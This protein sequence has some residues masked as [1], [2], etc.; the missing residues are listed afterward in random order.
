M[1]AVLVICGKSNHLT[2]H[3]Y[4]PSFLWASCV[5]VKEHL[6][7]LEILTNLNLILGL[8]TDKIS[9]VE[10]IGDATR[11]PIVIDLI[12]QGFGK[13]EL[14]R[15]LNSL[16][17]IGR[18]A[19]LQ[20]AMLSPLF[21]VSSFVVEEY[22]ALPVSITYRFGQ[23]EKTATRELFKKGSTFP[24]SKTV[25]FDNKL[26]EMDLLVHYTKDQSDILTGLPD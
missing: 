19:A 1:S 2:D 21:S 17:C 11:T 12:K 18:G 22:N 3:N 7:H 13:S 24:L 15:T 4:H 26:G 9:C 23:E 20:S 16:E 8:S 14:F 6:I 10:L 5:S 25:T